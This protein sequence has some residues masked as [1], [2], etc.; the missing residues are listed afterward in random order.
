MNDLSN[1]TNVCCDGYDEHCMYNNS[2]NETNQNNVIEE[3]SP[4]RH[5]SMDQLMGMLNEMGKS[6]R[7]RSLSDSGQDEGKIIL[8]I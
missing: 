1:L 7:T 2:N 8:N 6:S 5:N 4:R 3:S